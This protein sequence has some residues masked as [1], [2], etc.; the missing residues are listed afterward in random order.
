MS[1]SDYRAPYDEVLDGIVGKTIASVDFGHFGTDEQI[2]LRFT[3]GTS[4]QIMS[5]DSESYSSTLHVYD[6]PKLNHYET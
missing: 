2:V 1:I 6:P 5:E 3:D 4:V